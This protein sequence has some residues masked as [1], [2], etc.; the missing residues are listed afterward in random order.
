VVTED[1]QARHID[2]MG[3]H[4]E[5]YRARTPNGSIDVDDLTLDG[6]ES[7]QR[8]GYRDLTI[9]KVH[10]QVTSIPGLLLQ[11]IRERRRKY[12][13]AVHAGVRFPEQ[14]RRRD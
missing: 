7:A 6:R 2:E 9:D 10:A 3:L 11:Q 12:R 4:P 1:D 5:D 13:A 8:Y 14:D